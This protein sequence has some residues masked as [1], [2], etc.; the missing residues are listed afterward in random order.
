MSVFITHVVV[1]ILKK[2]KSLHKSVR[3]ELQSHKVAQG[4]KYIS[5]QGRICRQ[6]NDFFKDVFIKEKI[7]FKSDQFF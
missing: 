3:A 2:I 4:R 5:P 1:I 7:L 6:K